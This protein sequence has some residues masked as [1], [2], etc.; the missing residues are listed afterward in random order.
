MKYALTAAT[1]HFGQLA[2]HYLR[3]LVDEK[4]IVLIVR[5]QEKAKALFGSADIREAERLGVSYGKYRAWKDGR[6]HIHG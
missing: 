3:E 4:D 2:Y 1:G 6:I 5:N